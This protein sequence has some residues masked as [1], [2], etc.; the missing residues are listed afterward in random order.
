MMWVLIM[1]YKKYIIHPFIYRT[2]MGCASAFKQLNLFVQSPT[3]IFIIQLD[4]IP[5]DTYMACIKENNKWKLYF[6]KGKEGYFQY[7]T[8]TLD[9]QNLIGVITYENLDKLTS[10]DKRLLKSAN[11]YTR[12]KLSYPMLRDKEGSSKYPS[13]DN[14]IWITRTLDC[15]YHLAL[16]DAIQHIPFSKDRVLFLKY[17]QD[18]DYYLF[19]NAFM[20]QKEKGKQ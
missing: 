7:I 12:G 14:I 3:R 5:I 17:N 2:L 15:A 13:T 19:T 4:D 11:V 8:Q 10:M 6:L 9:E 16:R 18:K 1:A 20:R